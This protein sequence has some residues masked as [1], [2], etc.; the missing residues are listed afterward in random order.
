MRLKLRI[1]VFFSKFSF[2][3]D[4]QKL[5]IYL[6]FLFIYTSRLFLR[7]LI[8]ARL[9]E[10]GDLQNQMLAILKTFSTDKGIHT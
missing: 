2:F 4:K 3:S 7:S 8:H 5:F 9:K 1:I 6:F 10:F